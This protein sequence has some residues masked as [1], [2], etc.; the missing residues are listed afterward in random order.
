MNN[1]SV[2]NAH[3]DIAPE[4]IAQLLTRATQQLDD[5]T[6]AALR[7]SRIVALERQSAGKPVSVLSTGHGLHW[8]MPH[9]THQWVATVILF[10][11]I[12]FGGVHYW[13]HTREVELAHLDAAI[14]TDDMPLE[15][16]V[17]NYTHSG[18]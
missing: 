18:Q 11:A 8:L 3:R 12:I 1:N 13:Q 17:D 6:V 5:T 7:R 2:D 15:A 9:S 4:R 14:L 10:A 16:F